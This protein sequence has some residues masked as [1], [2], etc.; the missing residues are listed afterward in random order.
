MNIPAEI[1]EL[2]GYATQRRYRLQ[3]G[4]TPLISSLAQ[5]WTREYQIGQ[6]RFF[7]TAFLAE[8]IG[9]GG[10]QFISMTIVWHDLYNSSAFISKADVDINTWP[11]IFIVETDMCGQEQIMLDWCHL[12]SINSNLARICGQWVIR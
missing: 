1:L 8:A 12:K 2:V 11:Q 7:L 4:D 5:I 3:T 6:R 9:K 10:T